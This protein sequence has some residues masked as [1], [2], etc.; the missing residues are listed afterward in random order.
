LYAI[1]VASSAPTN[2]NSFSCGACNFQFNHTFNYATLLDADEFPEAIKEKVGKILVSKH[3]YETLK[4]MHDGSNKVFRYKS[5]VT[6]NIYDIEPPSVQ[7]AVDTYVGVDREDSIALYTSVMVLYVKKIFLYNSSKEEYLEID[8][9]DI[10]MMYD[11][12]KQLPQDDVD[13]FQE[14]LPD[15]MFDPRFNLKTTCPQC[16]NQMTNEYAIT[17]LVFLRARATQ[18][19]FQA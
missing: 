12:V 4:E 14:I 8:D 6:G 10:K 15:M 19:Q 13:L 1:L 9:S 5:P 11:I 3:D 2:E 16:G 17:D 7:K 18:T